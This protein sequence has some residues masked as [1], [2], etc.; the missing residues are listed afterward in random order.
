MTLKIINQFISKIKG[1]DYKLDSRIPFSYVVLLILRRCFMYIR[2]NIAFIE[3][4]GLLFIGKGVTLRGRNLIKF[5]RGISIDDGCF[6]DALSD[7]GVCFENYVSLG[8]RTVI[9]CSGSLENL[10]KGFIVGNNVG[11]GRD[12]FYGC[13]GGIKIGSDTII[14]NYVSFHSEH[15]NSVFL[16]IPI[17]NQG[18]SRKG[19]SIGA[20]CWIGAKATILDGVKLGDGCIV[21]AGAVVTAGVYKGNAIY[22]G[23]PVKLLKTR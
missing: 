8:K 7:E 15:H 22:G 12:C 21:A 9:E 1:K 3:N 10:G 14:G 16:D 6:I 5:G 4:K 17:R 23:V 2:G 19:I 20:N 18:V 13:A 11:L